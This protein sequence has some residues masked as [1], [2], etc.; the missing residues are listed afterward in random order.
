M[1][2]ATENS[3]KIRADE[4]R[5]EQARHRMR[6]RYDW[7]IR[8]YQPEDLRD[9]HDFMVDLMT[10]LNGVHGEIA[11]AYGEA[12]ASQMQLAMGSF[13]QTGNIIPTEPK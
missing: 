11:A 3:A 5:A 9:R 12:H 6:D 10:V 2:T 13:L 1:S 7:F 4:M 8:K